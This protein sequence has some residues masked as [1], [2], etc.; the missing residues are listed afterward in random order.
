[1]GEN[2]GDSYLLSFIPDDNV[3]QYLSSLVKQ[4]SKGI[5]LGI[6]MESDAGKVLADIEKISKALQDEIGNKNFDMEKLLNLNT[7]IAQL[8]SF[9]KTAEGLPE[10]FNAMTSTVT[11][12]NGAISEIA[13]TKLDSGKFAS[14]QNALSSISA[15]VEAIAKKLGAIDESSGLKNV[16]Q[17]AKAAAEG[18]KEAAAATDELNKKQAESTNKDPNMDKTYGYTQKRIETLNQKINEYQELKAVMTA[19]EQKI[20]DGKHIKNK[21]EDIDAYT[22]QIKKAQDTIKELKRKLNDDNLTDAIEKGFNSKIA[23]WKRVIVDCENIISRINGQGELPDRQTRV[24]AIDADNRAI[25]TDVNKELKNA[26]EELQIWEEVA[27]KKREANSPD[28]VRYSEEQ[29]AKAQEAARLE[30]EAARKAAEAE[31]D[32]K[33]RIIEN[34]AEYQNLSAQVDVLTKEQR[35]WQEVIANMPKA[36]LTGVTKENAL[37]TMVDK[38]NEFYTLLEASDKPV[39][40][41]NARIHQLISDIKVLTTEYAEIFDSNRSYK[42]ANGNGLG[43]IAYEVNKKDPISDFNKVTQDIAKLETAKQQALNRT[44]VLTSTDTNEAALKA[45]YEVSQAMKQT[46]QAIEQVTVAAK[47]AGDTQVQA[48]KESNLSLEEKLALLKQI[49]SELKFLETAEDKRISYEEKAYD[50]GGNNPKSEADSLKKIKLYDDLIEHIGTANKVVD[51][52]QANYEELI[53]TLKNGEQIKMSANDIFDLTEIKLLK[54]QIKD[55]NFK[56]YEDASSTSVEQQIA[57][58]QTLQEEIKETQV[59]QAQQAAPSTSAQPMQQAAQDAAATAANVEKVE[60]NLTEAAAKAE[61]LEQQMAD[62][63]AKAAQSVTGKVDIGNT[64]QVTSG[65]G[66]LALEKTLHATYRIQQNMVKILAEINSKMVSGANAATASYEHLKAVMQETVEAGKQLAAD[67]AKQNEPYALMKQE[68]TEILRLK[69]LLPNAGENETK[70]IGEQ[71]NALYKQA[72]QHQKVIDKANARNEVEQSTVDLLRQQIKLQEASNKD[73]NVLGKKTKLETKYNS[74]RNVIKSANG[75]TLIGTDEAN[76]VQKV[77]DQFRQCDDAIAQVN[78]N[79]KALNSNQ[80]TQIK[81]AVDGYNTL[82]AA[83]KEFLKAGAY[84]E[85]N[86]SGKYQGKYTALDESQ[87]KALRA[88]RTGTDEYKNALVDVAEKA[89]GFKMVSAELDST[90]TKLISTYYDEDNSLKKITTSYHDAASQARIYQ[91]QVEAHKSVIKSVFEPLGNKMKE[92]FRYFSAYMIVMRF[93]N[94]FKEGIQ[95]VRELNTALTEMQLVTSSTVEEMSKV[96]KKIQDIAASV[97]STNT[98]IAQS[99]TDWARLG[100]SMSDALELAG[101]SAQ[102]AK[103]GFTDVATASENLTATMQA[104]YSKELAQGLVDAGDLAESLTDK[105]VDVG[106]K[107]A[108]SADGL[109]QGMTAASAALVAAGNDVDEAIAMITAGT[110]VLQDEAET[111]N[112]IKVLSMRLRGTSSKELEEAGEDTEGLLENASKLQA[113]IKKLTAVN[114]KEGISIVN[115]DTGAYKSTYEILLEISEVWDELTDANKAALLEKIAGEQSC[116]NYTE[117]Y[118]YRTHLIALI[119]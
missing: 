63:N 91:N 74:A 30:A 24:Q 105:F 3:S 99:A 119:A 7:V 45:A 50:A 78:N 61:V 37:S 95:Y 8:G 4:A 116:L 32:K 115:T 28:F 48:N 6:D 38:A 19:D 104:F 62:V 85:F 42:L 51:D 23:Y 9:T 111:A 102:Y 10:I 1:M 65:G 103:V 40:E 67:E 66:Q 88:M 79:F 71:I 41:I 100:Y 94:A 80:K 81:N 46:E 35:A 75:N 101:V 20:D 14:F 59:L 109:G 72:G 49:Q 113:T 39:D 73:N 43:A 16:N 90:G 64:V 33:K 11:S 77:V 36:D 96:E 15:N 13:S 76:K 12:L 107:F 21:G 58:Q 55:I 97:A 27:A 98:D 34:I 118:H 29:A 5:K 69:K 114:G 22:K 26:R 47:E 89:T 54:S 106:N 86:K 2:T 17:D 108:S 112:A 68:L 70:L 18:I 82:T 83:Q 56:S 60:Q 93:F 92:I 87:V 57:A 110:T 44:K 52:F 25:K 117:T 31:E 84:N 53:I